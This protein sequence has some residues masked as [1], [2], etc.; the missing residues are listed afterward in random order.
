M[1]ALLEA[2]TL[3]LATSPERDKSREFDAL[4][5]SERTRLYGIAYSILRD[6]REAEDA[7]QDAMLRAWK[8]WTHLRDEN[9]RSGW[10]VRI[11][12]N[13]SIT[14]RKKMLQRWS[15]RPTNESDHAPLEAALTHDL[16]DLDRW[17]GLLSRKQRA[18]ILLH[19]H[20]GYSIEEC[21]ALMNCGAGSVRTHLARAIAH[22]RKEMAS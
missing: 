20:F 1:Q 7:F 11:V 9:T 12:V 17:Y 21:S 3:H 10:M 19:Y 5:D 18:A 8:G 16:M 22:M 13:Q 2:P 14:H 6:H 15:Q 4:L